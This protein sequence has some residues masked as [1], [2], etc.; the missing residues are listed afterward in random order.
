MMSKSVKNYSGTYDKA[1]KRLE[2]EFNSFIKTEKGEEWLKD[3]RSL[4]C[5]RGD[6]GDYL[7]DFYPE[8][9]Q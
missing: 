9:L 2:E 5:F 4:E 7:Y 8:M 3:G 1:I 6:F